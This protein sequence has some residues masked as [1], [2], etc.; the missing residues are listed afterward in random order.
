MEL[1]ALARLGLAFGVVMFAPGWLL[2]HANCTSADPFQRFALYVTVSLAVWS[3]VLLWTSTL[4]LVLNEA[5]VLTA[6]LLLAAVSVAWFLIERG[7][8]PRT[9]V[10]A[11]FLQGGLLSLPRD[12]VSL[13]V[14]AVF[15]LAL[16][17]RFVAVRGLVIPMWV[18]SYQ[19]TLIV[20]LIQAHGALPTDYA[21]Y[22]PLARFTYHFGF[23][24]AAALFA[25]LS[26][27]DPPRAILILGQ[28]I[29]AAAALGAYLLAGSL[30]GERKAGLGA[31]LLVGLV[32]L[33]PAGFVNWGRYTLLT[34]LVVLP[35]AFVLA[36]QFVEDVTVSW[37]HLLLAV[38]AVSGVALAHY[39]AAL[40]LCCLLLA[41]GFVVC[42][43]RVWQRVPPSPGQVA[44]RCGILALGVLVMLLPWL[45]HLYLA[46]R[47]GDSVALTP[48]LTN[49]LPREVASMRGYLTVRWMS[50]GLA[51]L[52]ASAGATLA[53]FQR[54]W[55]ICSLV[56]MIPLLIALPSVG[57]LFSPLAFPGVVLSQVNP[58]T[59]ALALYLPIAALAGYALCGVW[60]WTHRRRAAR[61]VL[62]I[63]LGL[64][65]LVGFVRLAQIRNPSLELVRPADLAAFDWV[66]S[67]TPPDAVFLTNVAFWQGNLVVGTDAGYWLPILARRKMLALPALYSSEKP[68]R[69]AVLELR[70]V[71]RIERDASI[72]QSA[73]LCAL[74]ARGVRF[75]YVGAI[76]SGP[77]KPAQLRA[78]GDRVRRI[79]SKDGAQVYEILDCSNAVDDRGGSRF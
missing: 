70:D 49:A 18:D 9:F 58:D 64:T 57:Q 50:D 28:A 78:A 26:G 21:P 32:L 53:V 59:I 72:L 77:L 46:T 62:A 40:I 44:R 39:S 36:R 15:I 22:A 10:S 43:P 11:R 6:V 68:D 19:H 37:Y 38:I 17:V 61:I 67:H 54:R 45:I 52:L 4:G 34:G 29:N 79:Y 63:A 65:G 30:T 73:Q 66:Q 71:A 51:V 23:H 74:R 20:Q 14:F 76:R 69:Q 2:L 3:S 24:S 60:N 16:F 25:W 5:M 56:L 8:V 35:A 48:I 12:R 42:L 55:R 75:I 7:H 33:E 41:Y 31:A 47:T 1:V 13:G 27:L